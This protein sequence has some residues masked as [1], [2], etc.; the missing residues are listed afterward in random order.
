VFNSTYT[1]ED[2]DHQ[3]APTLS[4][5]NALQIS[6]DYVTQHYK[7]AHGF[8]I[9]LYHC[10]FSGKIIIWVQKYLNTLFETFLFS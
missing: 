6:E 1:P 3:D 10:L 2:P 8:I 9:N 4:D 7:S 5:Q